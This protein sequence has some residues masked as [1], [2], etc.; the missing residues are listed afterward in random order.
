MITVLYMHV[1]I[2]FKYITYNYS[3][4]QMGEMNKNVENNGK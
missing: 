1:F 3:T 2:L 4:L